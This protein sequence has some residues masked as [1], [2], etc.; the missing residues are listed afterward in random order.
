FLILLVSSV[1]TFCFS[2]NLLAQDAIFQAGASTVNI[3]PSLGAGI[4]GNHGTPPPATHIHDELHARSLVL[5]D[6]KIRLVFVVVDN[7]GINREVFDEAKRLIHE[8]TQIPREHILMSA[9]HTHSSISAR[10]G[11]VGGNP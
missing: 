6:G 11:G 7:V 10:G 9:N 5:D 1:L 2:M 3:T 4:V 8:E